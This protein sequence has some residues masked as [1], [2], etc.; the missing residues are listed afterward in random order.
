MT[1]DVFLLLGVLFVAS[2]FNMIFSGIILTR[3]FKIKIKF[4]FSKELAKKIL[5]IALPF[6]LAAIFAKVYAY[7]DTF[8]L[9]MFLGDEEVGFYSIAYK[10]TFALQFIPLAFVA[11][12]Y[13]AFANYFKEDYENLKRVFIKSFNYLA[14]IA[15]PV[16]FGVIALADIIVAKLYTSEFSFSVLPLQVLIASIPFL[17][18]NFSLSSFLNAT[19]RQKINTRNL[20]IIMVFNIVA[21]IILIPEIGIWGAALASSL[22]TLFL[23]G[24][25]L[26]AVLRVIKV[27]ARSFLPILG[28]IFSS[29]IMFF[30]ITYFYCLHYSCS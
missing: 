1:D 17:F 18:V 25:N 20:G 28:S 13:P 4:Y 8:L 7:I 9:K 23:F 21:N 26:F 10:I 5:L 16:A 22:S 12:L 6:A 19:N 27:A 30:I 2:L 15:I 11:S 3:K 24:L 29:L 14:F